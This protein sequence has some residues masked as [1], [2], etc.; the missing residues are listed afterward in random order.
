MERA[1]RFLRVTVEGMRQ[2][3]AEGLRL[4]PSKFNLDRGQRL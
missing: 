3:V 1:G 4:R 2:R